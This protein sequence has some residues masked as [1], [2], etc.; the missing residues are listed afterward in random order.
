[1]SFTQMINTINLLCAFNFV[2]DKSSM[3]NWD[4]NSYEV[5]KFPSILTIDRIDNW[6]FTHSLS[7]VAQ[8]SLLSHSHV[9]TLPG[10]KN[11]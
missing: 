10:I 4:I 8:G 2:K 6:S 7:S 3:G 9:P 11:A 5:V 1:M